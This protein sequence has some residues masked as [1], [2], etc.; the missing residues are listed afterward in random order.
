[1]IGGGEIK[2]SSMLSQNVAYG[3]IYDLLRGSR[4]L[5]AHGSHCA[6]AV[7]S[8]CSFYL[9]MLLIQSPT[10]SLFPH[11]I[12][13]KTSDD[14][15]SP[16]LGVSPRVSLSLCFLASFRLL[17]GLSVSVS[18]I[19]RSLDRDLNHGHFCISYAAVC[20]LALSPAS[21]LPKASQGPSRLKAPKLDPSVCQPQDLAF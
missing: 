21:D 18:V 17:A 2:I 1:M 5:P 3:Q 12:G 4:A 9:R 10:L 16:F 15:Q 20:R 8:A 6:H 11:V 13:P 19:S 7:A 14:D